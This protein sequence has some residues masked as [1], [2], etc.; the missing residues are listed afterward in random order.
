MPATPL[1]LADPDLEGG[2]GPARPA[3]PQVDGHAL[4]TQ[5]PTGQVPAFN[6]M[7]NTQL[8]IF[9]GPSWD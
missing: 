8:F 3:R 5:A 6:P 4:L 1:R 7:S 9:K 2:P